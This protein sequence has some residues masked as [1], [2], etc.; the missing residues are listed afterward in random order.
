M[1]GRLTALERAFEL[2]RSG[3]C[4]GVAEIRSQLKSE[5]FMAAERAIHG[6]SLTKQLRALCEAARDDAFGP[7]RSG[8]D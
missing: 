8:V 4:A 5:G 7:K 1:T 2:A 6:P 3:T